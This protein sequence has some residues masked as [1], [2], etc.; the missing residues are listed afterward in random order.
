[1]IYLTITDIH[2]KHITYGL[3][4]VYA[5]LLKQDGLASVMYAEVVLCVLLTDSQKSLAG[6]ISNGGENV[7]SK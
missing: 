1:M 3:T 5:A 2:R 7:S 6:M 4:S